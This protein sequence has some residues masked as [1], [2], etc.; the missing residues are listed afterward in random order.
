MDTVEWLA[1]MGDCT[2]SGRIRTEADDTVCSSERLVSESFRC[3]Y[4][5]VT[6]QYLPFILEESCPH[7][8]ESSLILPKLRAL[9]PPVRPEEPRCRIC[10]ASS[11][12]YLLIVSDPTTETGKSVAKNY[13]MRSLTCML[14]RSKSSFMTHVMRHSLPISVNHEMSFMRSERPDL[15][16][17]CPASNFLRPALDA[18]VFHTLTSL[19]SDMKR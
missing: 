17:R 18:R 19:A 6:V 8:F 2:G 7:Q 9:S 10:E 4:S 5:N 3:T 1:E 14:E 15:M 12:G 16:L 11:S 13:H